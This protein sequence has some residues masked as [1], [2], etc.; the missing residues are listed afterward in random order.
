MFLLIN[1]LAEQVLEEV[2]R[3]VIEYYTMNNLYPDNLHNE[4]S[5]LV[6]R[7]S[8]TY[9]INNNSY[10]NALNSYNSNSNNN[11]YFSLNIHN[12]GY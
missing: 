9:Q 1:I 8:Q 3:Q 6:N 4:E 2:P 11:G 12:Q 7:I 10:N 5:V